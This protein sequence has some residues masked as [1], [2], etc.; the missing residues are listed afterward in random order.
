[1][2]DFGDADFAELFG[3]EQNP[4]NPDSTRSHCGYIILLGGVPL[5][6]KSVLMTAICLSTLKAEY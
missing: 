4:R 3:S 5:F 6:W 1:M 2:V